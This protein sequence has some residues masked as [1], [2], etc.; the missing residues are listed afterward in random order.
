[1]LPREFGRLER[2]SLVSS[3]A[4]L[5]TGAI[6]I[7]IVIATGI[8][9]GDDVAFLAS[10]YSFGVL[11]AFTAAQLAVMRLRQKEPELER[12]F[13]ARPDVRIRAS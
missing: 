4:L 11:L 13:R 10:A 3:E 8:F 5:A 9:A 12:P 7:A 1:M 2:R 6:A